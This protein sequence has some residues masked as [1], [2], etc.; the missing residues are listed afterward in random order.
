MEPDKLEENWRN[1]DGTL[2]V[3]HPPMGG[4]PKG[5]TL[6]EYQAEKFRAMTDEEKE[7]FLKEITKDTRWKMA[8]GNPATATDITSGGEKITI[9]FDESFKERN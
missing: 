8:E 3:G 9:T 2:K 4:R 7:E 5:K 1:A 6:K